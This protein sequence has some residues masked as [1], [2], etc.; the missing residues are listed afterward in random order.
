M[1]AR[2]KRRRWKEILAVAVILSMGYLFGLVGA[3]VTAVVVYSV[4]RFQRR[5][6]NSGLMVDRPTPKAEGF[7][8]GASPLTNTY[9]DEVERRLVASGFKI[10]R[11]VTLPNFTVDLVGMKSEFKL[12][13]FGVLARFVFVA[14]THRLPVPVTEEVA[15]QFSDESFAYALDNRGG[16]LPRGGGGSVFSFSALV[17]EGSPSDELKKRIQERR[18]P[19]HWGAS[20]FPVFVSLGDRQLYYCKKAPAW[21]RA[22]YR[23]QK[24]FVE[25]QLA[26]T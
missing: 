2:G 23:G 4:Y 10:S 24:N 16:F 22:Y 9:I 6:R 8:Q 3:V 11:N 7:G 17:S 19:K 18:G 1:P 25:R 15:F 21:G 14:S 26:V 13:M 12:S 5:K 20:E